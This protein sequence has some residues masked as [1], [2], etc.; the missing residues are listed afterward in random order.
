[1]YASTFSAAFFPLSSKAKGDTKERTVAL[2]KREKREAAI[3]TWIMNA[4]RGLPTDEDLRKA[5]FWESRRAGE[6]AR[7][8]LVSIKM[9][10]VICV[11]P[12]FRCGSLISSCAFRILLQAEQKRTARLQKLWRAQWYASVQL[13]THQDYVSPRE[14]RDWHW[15][16]AFAI[17]QGR[18]FL[19]WPSAQDFDNGDAPAGRIF[20][21]GHAGLAGLSPLEMRQMEAKE[22]PLV[23][24]IF[25]RGLN[26]QQK[27]TILTETVTSKDALETAVL[28]ASTKQD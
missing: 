11:V 15:V 24:S 12:S 23:V 10:I 25:G 28:E 7:A 27:L 16:D 17:I 14:Q 6:E 3:V 5:Y 4:I 9:R 26:G 20:L 2:E 19:W 8:E 1:M 21:A 13:K 18:R 22:T